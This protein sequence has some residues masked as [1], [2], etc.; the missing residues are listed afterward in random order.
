MFRVKFNAAQLEASLQNLADMAAKNASET[1]RKTAIRIRDLAREYAPVDTGLLESNIEY[2]AFKDERR[3]NVFVVYINL[4][5]VNEK[6]HKDLGDYAW[7][8]EEE[9]H[10]FG[11]QK[12]RLYFKLGKK[13]ALKAASGRKVGGRFLSRAIQEGTK[14]MV[15]EATAAVSRTLS[16]NRMVAMNY[17]REIGGNE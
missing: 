2:A 12:S 3:R 14:Q 4:D 9:L 5:A 10:P 15:A 17:Q 6:S 8:M 16:G 7:I 11:R 13:S 1:L